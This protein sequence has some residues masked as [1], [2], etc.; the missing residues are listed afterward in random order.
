MFSSQQK[1]KQKQKQSTTTKQG[2]ENFAFIHWLLFVIFQRRLLSEEIRN[3]KHWKFETTDDPHFADIKVRLSN[4]VRIVF[5]YLF[6]RKVCPVFCPPNKM[7]HR[8]PQGAA[9]R[10]QDWVKCI[11][12]HFIVKLKGL[13]THL[14]LGRSD[15]EDGHSFTVCNNEQNTRAKVIFKGSSGK[16]HFIYLLRLVGRLSVLKAE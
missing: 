11:E 9:N 2:N 3:C 14:P 1:Q 6:E 4:T 7:N 8:V 5:V 10:F 13:N 16:I 12:S 15:K